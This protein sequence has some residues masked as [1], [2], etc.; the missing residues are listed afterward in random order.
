MI[1]IQLPETLQIVEGN[2]NR[3]ELK[4][5][6]EKGGKYPSIKE[7]LILKAHEITETTRIVYDSKALTV[8]SGKDQTGMYLSCFNKTEEDI[9][10][11]VPLATLDLKE[12]QNAY[13][14]LTAEELVILDKKLTLLIPDEEILLVKLT[15]QN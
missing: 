9:T 15:T 12:E 5:I 2:I 13:C 3:E 11:E 1:H 4:A 6:F 14:V 10:L 8:L 7:Q